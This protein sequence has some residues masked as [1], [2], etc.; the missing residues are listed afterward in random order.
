MDILGTVDIRA[1]T[2]P[3]Y[4]PPRIILLYAYVPPVNLRIK[5]VPAENILT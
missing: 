2:S 3:P 1:S 4:F 5:E